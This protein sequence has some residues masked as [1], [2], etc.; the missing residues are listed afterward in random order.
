[1]HKFAIRYASGAH[2]FSRK[3]PAELRRPQ[4]CATVGNRRTRLVR[5][6]AFTPNRDP[7]SRFG[8]RGSDLE[9]VH[10]RGWP[11]GPCWLSWRGPRFSSQTRKRRTASHRT[12]TATRALASKRAIC[13]RN[14]LHRKISGIPQRRGHPRPRHRPPGHLRQSELLRRDRLNR[15][16]C[17]AFGQRRASILPG[18]RY[19]STSVGIV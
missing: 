19:A 2:A 11:A 9:R 14:L 10:P 1:M 8:E 16:D 6:R 18:S 5:R 17:R 13:F 4:R 7:D 15:Q 12:A 3:S